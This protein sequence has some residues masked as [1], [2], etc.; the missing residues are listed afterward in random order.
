MPAHDERVSVPFG[1]FGY[2]PGHYD[3][4]LDIALMGSLGQIC[5]ADQ[6][7]NSVDDDAF[8]VK[9]GAVAFSLGKAARVKKQIGQPGSWPFV[10]DEPFGEA[11]QQRIRPRRVSGSAPDIDDKVRSLA[12]AICESG[13]DF[14]GLVDCKA[15]DQHPLLGLRE[16]LAHH[17]TCVARRASYVGAARHQLD[18]GS[19]GTRIPLRRDCV[20]QQCYMLQTNSRTQ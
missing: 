13:E 8:S 14:T 18:N 4:D 16:Q 5:R 2:Y 12:H 1:G 7:P 15:D 6:C 19:I 17:D 9:A 20:E 3:T 11:P 10:P